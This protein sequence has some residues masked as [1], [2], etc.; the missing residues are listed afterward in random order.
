[1]LRRVKIKTLE[2]SSSIKQ[3]RTIENWVKLISFS[4]EEHTERLLQ[5]TSIAVRH[6]EETVNSI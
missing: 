5:Q 1:M 6:E 3:E 2:F 4:T